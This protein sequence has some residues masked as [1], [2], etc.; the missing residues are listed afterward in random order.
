MATRVIYFEKDNILYQK[1]IEMSQVDGYAYLDKTSVSNAILDKSLDVPQPCI[2]VSSNTRHM[3]ELSFYNV[4]SDKGVAVKDLWDSISSCKD[5]EF[6]PPGS[7][8]LIYL[9]NLTERQIM[10]I[11][12]TGSFY[13]IYYNPTSNKG[14]VAR[15][16]ACLKLL[17]KQH[18][19]DY[20]LD[21][22]KF[23]WW[24]YANCS[25]PVRWDN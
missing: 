10:I 25:H 24:Y 6:L 2:D 4:K 20:I 11:L 9:K 13:D 16:C 22:N 5:I 3:R 21:M 8:E 18:K 19:L 1:R 7:Y 14:S 23:L 17:A 12:N 15:A